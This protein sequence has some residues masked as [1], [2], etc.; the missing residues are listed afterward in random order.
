VQPWL[1]WT[2]WL[3]LPMWLACMM[4]G[5][6]LASPVLRREAI[7]Q[8]VPVHEVT[9][10]AMAA[11]PTVMVGARLGHVVLEAPRTYLDAPWEVLV[12]TRGGFVFYAG[13]LAGGL[14]L[15]H[16]ARRAQLDPWALGDVFAPATAFGLAFGRLGCLAAGCCHGPPTAG[17]WGLRYLHRGTVPDDWLGR[18]LVPTPLWEALACLGL[19]VA[20]DAVRRRGRRG[21]VLLAFLAGYGLLRSALELWRA[22]AERGLWWGGLV[23][24]SQVIGVGSAAVAA[25][26]WARRKATCTPS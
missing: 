11:V 25:A 24:T 10:L 9:G 20:L 12:F 18:P 26:W 3:K 6:A 17:G 21:E 2:P 22:D 7:R 15:W 8:G 16:W 13:L 5:F 23:S 19:F 1:V 14:L 4:G